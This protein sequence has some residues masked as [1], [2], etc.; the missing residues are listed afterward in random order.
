MSRVVPLGDLREA[1]LHASAHTDP[2]PNATQQALADPPLQAA[3]IRLAGEQRL[4]P[5]A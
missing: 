2:H 3:L 5:A 1:A 4:L